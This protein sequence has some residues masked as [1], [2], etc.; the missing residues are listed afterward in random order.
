MVCV[1][2]DELKTQIFEEVG[3]ALI[4]ADALNERDGMIDYAENDED[5]NS[6]GQ[7]FNNWDYWEQHLYF[8]TKKQYE[9][10]IAALDEFEDENEWF[11]YTIKSEDEIDDD[12]LEKAKEQNKKNKNK[13]YYLIEVAGATGWLKK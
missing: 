12:I 9:K 3:L 1:D 10:Q 6:Y 5:T 7:S 8:L 11:T 13:K 2:E 4:F